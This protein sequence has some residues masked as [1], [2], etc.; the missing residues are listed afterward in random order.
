[1]EY[2]P[3]RTF[4]TSHVIQSEQRA[5]VRRK[6]SGKFQAPMPGRTLDRPFA[7]T[8]RQDRAARN[9]CARGT[10]MWAARVGGR[11][12]TCLRNVRSR[13]R[14]IT[15]SRASRKY[16]NETRKSGKAANTVDR[17]EISSRISRG[18]SINRAHD[19]PRTRR[20]P[21]CPKGGGGRAKGRERE[22]CTKTRTAA[23]R[24]GLRHRRLDDRSCCSC[25]AEVAQRARVLSIKFY[26]S[27]FPPTL[28]AF[29]PSLAFAERRLVPSCTFGNV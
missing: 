6:I 11:V 4:C 8:V 25:E 16:Y 14:P 22:S 17:A 9:V 3:A 10:C 20:V 24:C 28:S 29:S 18:V 26:G 13:Q 1:M 19:A 2:V 12:C 15:L 21:P 27:S 7:L 5:E 23:F